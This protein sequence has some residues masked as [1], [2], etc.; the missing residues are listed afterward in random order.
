MITGLAVIGQTVSSAIA[1]YG[2][3][4]FRFRGKNVLF[5]LMLSTLMVPY[6]ITLIPQF[7]IFKWLGWINTFYP[8]I[9]PAFFGTPFYIFLYRQFFL[10]IPGEY[11]D[12]AA[13][14]GCS[15]W[16][17]FLRIILPMSLPVVG[18]V[19]ILSFNQ[20]WNDFL[21][22]LIYINTNAKRTIQL[23]INAMRNLYT[24]EWHLL[25]AASVVALIPTVL[26][27]FFLQ[28]RMIQG[29]VVSGIK[30]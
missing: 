25:M 6:H 7:V 10:Q 11:N 22:P 30:G 28:R 16:G 9:V 17:A 18:T 4:K 26:I 24:V 13:I 8:L 14:D 2:F 5:V 15:Y 27:F 29:I 19:A 3:A 21:G 23:G 1:G 12:A 20:H